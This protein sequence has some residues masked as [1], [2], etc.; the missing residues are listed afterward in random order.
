MPKTLNAKN[1]LSPELRFLITCCQTNQTKE[2]INSIRSY[3][4]LITNYQSLITAATQHGILPLVYKTIK[5]VSQLDSSSLN[6]QRLT[7]LE[8]YPKGTSS[9]FCLTANSDTPVAKA[10]V[11]CNAFLSELKPLYMSI[12]QRN[13]LMTS[14]LIKI[15][16]LLRENNIEALAFKGPT[17]SQMAYGDIT[18]R[19]FGDLDILIKKRTRSQM[20]DL[21]LKEHY[22]P[23]IDLKEGTKE[24]FFNSVNVIAFY[25]ESTGIRIEVHWELLSRNYAIDWEEKKLWDTQ[26]HT[27]INHKEIP[28]LVL[29]QQLLYLSAHGAKHLFERLEW[30]C[31]IDRSIRVDPNINW[32]HLLN[33]A[34]K[35][36]IKRMLYLGLELSRKFFGLDLPEMIK[37]NIAQDKEIPK[38]I[39]KVI[40]VNF[41]KTSQEKKS[42][43]T[44][45]LLWNMRENLSDQI[46]F[47][48]RGLFAPKF[49][50]FKYIQL[51]KYLAFLYPVVR[52][53]RLI[54]K[55]F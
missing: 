26:E 16:H 35:L 22:I 37:K 15:M 41:S 30:I 24:T 7:L 2:D 49:D 8:L 28:V 52:P 47:A 51:P 17:L 20:M 38:L 3:L 31:D 40:Q 50:D 1:N 9:A 12:V 14:E 11:G 54:T 10:Q 19:Q 6:A 53:Y 32:Q 36:G 25:N 39:S 13:M 27:R 43:S 46:R 29:E 23:E 44:F 34:E 48:W 55:Y 33:E 5:D 18:L 42:Y 21:L 45:G 4:S